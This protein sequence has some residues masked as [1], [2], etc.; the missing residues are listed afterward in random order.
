MK[1]MLYAAG[2]AA[3]IAVSSCGDKKGSSG[4]KADHSNV[5]VDTFADIQVLKYDLPGWDKL[6]PKQKELIYYLSE[7]ALS[8]RDIYWDQ[9]CRENLRVRKTLEA[10]HAS[11]SGKK[12]GADWEKFNLYS[13]RVFFSNGIHH[14]YMES[15]IQPEFSKEYFKTLI[16]GSKNLPLENGQSAAQLAEYLT[17]V[18]F[19]PT[20]L[21]KRTNKAEGIDMLQGSAMNFY[22]NVS[23]TEAEKFYGDMA[24][25]GGKDAPSYGLNSKLT[26]DEKGA[27]VERVWKLGGMYGSAIEKMIYWLEK[28]KTV[29]ENPQQE[30]AI[31]LLIEYYKTGDL[32]TWDAFSIAWVEDTSSVVDFIHGFIEVYVDPIGHKATYESTIQYRDPEATEKMKVIS[33]NA[34][35][36]EDN[37]PILPEHK[38]KKVTGISYRVINVAMEAG[39]AAPS[40]P[41]G[42]NLPN[43]EWIRETYGSKSVSLNNIIQA[44][45]HASGP[46]SLKE[47][48]YDQAEIDRTLKHGEL[49]DKLHTALHE[50]IGH[51]SGQLNP[52]VAQPHVTL[53]NYASTLEEARA[54]LVALYYLMDQK[55]VDLGVMPSLEVGKAEYDRYIRNGLLMQLRRLEMGQN[56]EEDHMR[57]RQLVAAWVF[58]K[59]QA[60]KV[61]EKVEKNGKTFYHINDYVKL[62]KLFGDLLREIQRIKSTGDFA[63]AKKLVEGYGV[64]VD[65]ATL[66]QVKDRFAT[67]QSKPYSGFIQPILKPVKGKDGKITDVK[68]E[69]ETDFLKQMLRFGKDY[70][71]LPI[72]N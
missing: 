42:V 54:D 22:Q 17:P 63:S 33:G 66:K 59:G 57:N 20:V 65:Q 21:A 46:G 37:S 41:I 5:V 68:V 62:R 47:F 23:N 39:D 58:E 18:M 48:C 60:E 24:A 51:A 25:K 40:T 9:N 11:Y 61:I 55:M 44:Y 49:G 34:Q 30:K 29:A 35:W 19:D 52:G 10:I 6:T 53:K 70:S 16:E 12:E 27:L 31:G 64:K 26:K 14:H 67:I 71:F 8:G 50:V 4:E 38:K 72:K 69:W 13:K 43:A 1:Q 56:L 2:I 28:A 15:K 32:K 7:A 45:D 36:F 3:T